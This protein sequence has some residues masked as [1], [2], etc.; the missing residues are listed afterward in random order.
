MNTAA[1]AA[2]AA[3]ARPPL[4]PAALAGAVLWGLFEL[5][6]LWRSRWRGPSAG[7]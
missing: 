2:P 1:P 7:R 4:R 3:P 6:A 5:V